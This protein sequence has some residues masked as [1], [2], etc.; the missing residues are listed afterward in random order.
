MNIS[1]SPNVRVGGWLTDT[2]NVAKSLIPGQK[3]PTVN[4]TYPANPTPG[5]VMPAILVGG[6]VVAVGLFTSRRRR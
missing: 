5:W 6:A 1:T 3:A 2:L 4:V